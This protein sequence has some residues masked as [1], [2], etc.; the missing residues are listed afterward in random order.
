MRNDYS[1]D[2]TGTATDSVIH[3]H[4]GS[5][6]IRNGTELYQRQVAGFDPVDAGLWELE[7]RIYNNLGNALDKTLNQNS[8]MPNAHRPAVYT[9][10]QFTD[11]MRSEFNKYKAK[12]NLTELNSDTYYDGSDKFTWNY[13]SVGP[14]IGGWRGLYHYFFN[15]DR[16]HTHPWEMLGH[17]RQPTWWD[18]NY[19]WTDAT[20]RSAL[21]LALQYGQT[22]DPSLGANNQTFDINYAYKNYDWNTNT[23]VTLAGVLNDPDTANVVPTP[24]DPAKDFVYGDWGPVEAQWRRSSQG[25]LAMII[26]FLRTRPLI[27]LNNYFRTARRELKNLA[28]YDHPQEIDVNELKLRSWK[29]I[30]ISGSSILGKIIESVNIVD[31][32]SGY[33]SAPSVKVNDNFGI[34]GLIEVYID[35]GAIIGA[36]V[37]N[38]GQKYF[39][40]PLVEVSTGSAILDPI[41]AEGAKHYYNGL[42]N[43]ITSFSEGY[44]TSADVLR[45]RLQNISFQGL[46]KAGGFVN[47]N[48]K[49]ILE[50]SQDKGRVFIPEENIATIMY[51]SKPDVEYFYG[52]IKIDKT[53]NGYTIN[54]YDNSLSYF[55]YNKPNTATDG[56]TVNFSGVTDVQVK[57]YSVF[58]TGITQLD[59]NTELRL[60]QEVYDFI[61]GYGYYLNSLGF[62]QQWRTAS[63][64]FVTWAVGSST[65]TLTIIPDETKIIVNDG[66]D[67]YFDN[68]DKRY[69]GVYN[70]SNRQ[71]NQIISNELIIDRK[72]MEPESETVFQV[73]NTDTEIFGIRLY[74]VQLE[75]AFVFDNFTNFDDVIHDLSIG[76]NHTRVIWQGSRTRDWN[77][78]LYSP[79]Y[80]V[81]NNIVI[82]NYDTTAKEVDQYLGRTNTLSNKQ[83]SDVARFNAGYN[84]PDWSEKLDIDE[85]SLYEFVKGSYKYKGTN[86]ALSAFMRNQGLFDG[87]ASAELLEQWA[88]R[89][90]DFGNTDKRRTLEF[91][92]TP[93]LLVT[94]PQPVRITDGEKFDVLSDIVIDIDNK[95]PLKVHASTE[96]NFQTRP[97]NTFKDSSDE[98]FAGDFS[99]SGLP[100]LSETDYRVINKEDF[101]KFPNQEEEL[102]DVYDHSGDWQDIGQWNAKISYKFNEKVL[103]QGKTW[104]ML[105]ADGS[106]GIA[107]ANDPI[108]VTGANQ[109]PVIPSSGQ[110]LIIDGNVITLSK[111]ASSETRNTIRVTGTEN[112]S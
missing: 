63:A 107:T 41:L 90:A 57:R 4:D 32:G 64:N 75:H 33:T 27:A 47:R 74:K 21:L 84:K 87:E 45:T 55:K 77:G 52:G 43:S 78:K 111:T 62:T 40:R 13:S 73:K 20:K 22:S 35:N 58:N 48:N 9:W 54:G 26:A 53:A 100:L 7:N 101:T 83:L 24:T 46:I 71:G 29:N 102:D 68:I 3:G 1:K 85:D 89:I 92:I 30:D 38:Q 105:D 96:D 6:H 34:D 8:Y 18:T 56:I 65:T 70:L 72:S 91:Q 66:T 99:T 25:K 5:V 106:S 103:Y 17:N 19:G 112:T 81:S 88:V 49:F 94:S 108:V 44:G 10:T 60:I 31:P 37:Q 110:T 79:G 69:D 80:I 42:S 28:G 67:G 98:L 86:H 93:N 104:S 59:Y 23:L 76:Q 82:P 11:T 15:T 36:S 12:N 39:N 14:G 97:V 61:N 109:L 16:P 50:S 2:S 51:T 95:S